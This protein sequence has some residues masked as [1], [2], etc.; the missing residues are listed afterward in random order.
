M[1][2]LN[3]EEGEKFEEWL[4]APQGV[5]TEV[6][7]YTPDPKLEAERLQLIKEAD[8]RDAADRVAQMSISE[9]DEKEDPEDTEMV[10]PSE[11]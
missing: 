6:E 2:A 3:A 1:W 9:E 8:A 10:T 11:R 7:T 4:C 5:S